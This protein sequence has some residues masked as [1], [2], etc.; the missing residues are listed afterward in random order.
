MV[1]LMPKWLTVDRVIGFLLLA[2][3]VFY[4]I[5]AIGLEEAIAPFFKRRAMRM[6]TMPYLLG[7]LAII[8]SLVTIIAPSTAV[9]EV[10]DEK[11]KDAKKKLGD[12]SFDNFS[13]YEYGK[14]AAM[15]AMMCLYAY[16]LRD[17]GFIPSTAIFLFAGS[18]LLG[19]RRWLAMIS[20]SILAPVLIWLLV[21]YVLERRIPPLPQGWGV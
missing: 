17:A 14:L 21:T 16:F 10:K 15:V 5:Q 3:S 12:L 4:F 8:A 7:I 20:V 9:A 19:E 2:A 11:V 6:D 1:V 13:D 18:L